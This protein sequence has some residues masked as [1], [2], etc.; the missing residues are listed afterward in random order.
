MIAGAHRHDA[1]LAGRVIQRQQKIQGAA[2]LEGG[3]ELAVLEFE[4]DFAARDIGQSARMAGGVRT[5]APTIAVAAA[6]MSARV[7][8]SAVM[9]VL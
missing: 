1:A 9:G 6:W 4:P 3:G 7:T 2:F 8:G 5:T